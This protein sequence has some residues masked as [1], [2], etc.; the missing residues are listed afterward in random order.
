MGSLKSC[1]SWEFGKPYWACAVEVSIG[2]PFILE[3]RQPG[4]L[5]VMSFQCEGPAETGRGKRQR[6]G[7]MRTRRPD[8]TQEGS[9][10]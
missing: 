2:N 8:A 9:F 5:C 7:L 10:P 3:I 6:W 4:K 1:I